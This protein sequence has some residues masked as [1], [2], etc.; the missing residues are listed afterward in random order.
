M[1]ESIEVM[2]SPTFTTIRLKKRSRME[3]CRTHANFLLGWSWSE[4][5]V[6][7]LYESRYDNESAVGICSKV[8]EVL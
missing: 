2:T 5:L 6:D 3:S 8:D 1:S 7:L 4:V